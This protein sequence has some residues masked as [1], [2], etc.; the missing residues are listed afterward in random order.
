MTKNRAVFAVLLI[1]PSAVLYL[2][3]YA[4]PTSFLDSLSATLTLSAVT[5]CPLLGALYFERKRAITLC[6]LIPFVLILTKAF[7][8]DGAERLVVAGLL[9]SVVFSVISCA[10]GLAVK[11]LYAKYYLKTI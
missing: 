1:G 2:L 5:L 8:F 7:D 11:Y 3:S 10:L 6:L 4:D 9:V